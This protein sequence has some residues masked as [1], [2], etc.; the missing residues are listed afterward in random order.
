MDLEWALTEDHREFTWT[1]PYHSGTQLGWGAQ[2]SR[3]GKSWVFSQ[4][5]ALEATNPGPRGQEAPQPASLTL[6]RKEWKH[7]AEP[8]RETPRVRP[9][10]A[11]TL[12]PPQRQPASGPVLLVGRN[13]ENHRKKSLLSIQR[14]GNSPEALWTSGRWWS[15]LPTGPWTWVPECIQPMGGTGQR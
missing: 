2:P 3:E 13:S 8:A 7:G 4:G 14:A 11:A 15:D 9:H 5:L 10:A 6:Q 12:R 1:P